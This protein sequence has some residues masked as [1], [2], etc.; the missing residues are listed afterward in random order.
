MKVGLSKPKI[1]F[2]DLVYNEN[3]VVIHILIIISNM[4][5][6]IIIYKCFLTKVF[7]L[8]REYVMMRTVPLFTVS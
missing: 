8:I 6:K 2:N 5:Y 1:S 4:K 7:C 3:S